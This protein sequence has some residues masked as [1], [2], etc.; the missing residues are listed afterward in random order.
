MSMEYGH[1]TMSTTGGMTLRLIGPKWNNI[2][3]G[4][5]GLIPP[6]NATALN[7]QEDQ[8]PDQLRLL[9]GRRSNPGATSDTT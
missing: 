6:P 8:D 2:Y 7:Y 5:A 1:F 9:P 4:N 3:A